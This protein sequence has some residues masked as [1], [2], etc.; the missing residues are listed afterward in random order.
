[1]E[2]IDT[3]NAAR[4]GNYDA[5]IKLGRLLEGNYEFSEEKCVKAA[6]QEYEI[7]RVVIPERITVIDD[8]AFYGCTSLQ[9]VY[10]HNS[11]TR[12]GECAFYQCQV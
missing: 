6:I 7:T 3:L 1:M 12:I 11:V 10:L 2:S 8:C 4:E 5:L 9:S